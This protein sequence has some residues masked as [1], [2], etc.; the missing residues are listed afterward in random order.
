MK[1]LSRTVLFLLC[2]AFVLQLV[3]P[4][5]ATAE[6]V[7]PG[8]LLLICNESA[9]RVR[10]D[11]MLRSCGVEVDGI[12]EAQYSTERL[13]GYTHV[14]TAAKEPYQDAIKA[15]MPV[16]FIGDQVSQIDGMDTLKLSGAAVEL[17]LGAHSERL[18]ENDLTLLSQTNQKSPFATLT[19]TSGETYPFG[20]L[21]GK[22]AYVPWYQGEG[23]AAVAFCQLVTKWLG[24][25]PQNRI[26]LLIDEIYP[27]SDLDML[28]KTA[29]SFHEKGMPFILRVMPVY[30]N[31]EY[32]AFLRYTQAL[33]YAQ[34]RGA[35][36]VLHDPLIQPY[37]TE[38]EPLKTKLKRAI[39]ALESAGILLTDMEFPPLS[40]DAEALLAIESPTREFGKL[41]IDTMISFS[42]FE[43]EEELKRATDI[44]DKK[45]LDLSSYGSQE[46]LAALNYDET[47][48]DIQYIFRE[49]EKKSLAGFFSNANGILLIVV[50]VSVVL[51]TALLLLGRKIYRRKFY[52]KKGE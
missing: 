10:I 20:L 22:D 49:E 50:G 42:L 18:F 47:P 31:L 21:S 39:T 6:Q 13:Q 7:K 44:L 37:E 4:T 17:S 52:K 28:C 38:R 23:L 8:R 30:E 3:F 36:I 12:N 41:P 16:L 34:F 27:F 2:S 29:D 1:H 43:T 14:V 35:T 46:H 48:I 33:R 19:L 9:G 51:F 25:T 40:L 24:T 32:P 45:W 5:I 15:A 26:F 11:E